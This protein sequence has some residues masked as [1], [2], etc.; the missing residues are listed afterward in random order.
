MDQCSAS[1]TIDVDA[2]YNTMGLA[3]NRRVA[4]LLDRI[5]GLDADGVLRS[6]NGMWMDGKNPAVLLNELN[7]LMRDVLMLHVAPRGALDLLSGGYDSATL[8]AFSK[9]L[10]AEELLCAMGTVQ[11]TLDRLRDAANPKM[12]VELCLV[13]LCEG[14]AGDSTAAL[15]ARISRLE[16][17]MAHGI[18]VREERWPDEREEDTYEDDA[19]SEQEDYREEEP[20]VFSDPPDE[21]PAETPGEDP[22]APP[23]SLSFQDILDAV[24]PQLPLGLRYSLDDTSKLRGT[25]LDDTLRL[26]ALPPFVYDSLNKQDILQLFSA[27]A[28]RLLGHEMRVQLTELRPDQPEQ[29]NLEELR[30]FSVVHFDD[31][32][33]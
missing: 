28:R 3:G 21:F 18:P 25:L 8:N 19:Y 17:D 33:H 2:V 16:E 29:R 20:P 5:L 24:K 26:Q 22:P 30:Q 4:E 7:A 11:D 13:S 1:E 32:K 15:R 14:A 27:E 12:Q 9:R 10:T 31:N 23:P 6:F